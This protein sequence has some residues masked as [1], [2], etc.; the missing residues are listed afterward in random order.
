M[1]L[2]LV[3]GAVIILGMVCYT[4]LAMTGH[5]GT[6]ILTFI[7]GHFLGATIQ[8]KAKGGNQNP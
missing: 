1:N 6:P 8:E 3:H 2:F 4:V 5:D 7:G